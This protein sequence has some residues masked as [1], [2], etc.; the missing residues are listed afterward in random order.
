MSELIIIKKYPNRRLYD[1]SSSQYVTLEN[2]FLM[3]KE[4]KEFRVEDVKSKEDLTKTV[5]TQIIFEQE[6]KG[7]NILPESFL[8]HIIKMYDNNLQNLF[9]L[10]L[11]QSVKEFAKNIEAWE[12]VG[13][14]YKDQPFSNYT[15]FMNQGIDYYRKFFDLF[16]TKDKENE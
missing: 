6:A 5:L 12:K 2:L 1:T 14:Q 8:K 16:S 13:G 7:Y 10:Y 3:I 15:N 11:E 4:G 9:S